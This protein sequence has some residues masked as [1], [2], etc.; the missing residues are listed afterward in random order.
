MAFRL[1]LAAAAVSLVT[2]CAT[3]GAPA[4]DPDVARGREQLVQAFDAAWVRVVASG[5]YYRILD[6][7]PK[8]RPGAARS[9]M[10][11]LADCLPHPDLVTFPEKPVGM[12]KRIIDTGEIRRGTQFNPL[13]KGDTAAYFSPISDALLDAMFVEIEKHYGVKL[14]VSEATLQLPSNETT[15][16]VV[17]GR[18]DFIDQLNAT[19]GDTQGMR[20]RA[21]RRFTCSIS[22]VTQ[23]IH[24][25]EKSPLAAKL[26]SWEDVRANK[27]VRI[28]TGPLSTQT[29]KSF[30]GDS[31]VQTK[32]IGDISNCVRAI[33]EG[34]ADVIANP[35]NDLSI[36][37][38]PGYK[39][40]HT[41]IVTG[42]PLWVA[43]EGIVCPS[44]GNP[45][46]ED[47]CR[48][49]EP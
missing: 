33:E 41:L 32:Y 20:R 13:G 29:M 7:F 27:D 4:V 24:V 14:K 2:G 19:G 8:E 31:R 49:E 34:K 39:R 37:G 47:Q 10:V 38:V 6:R 21:S 9:Y 30:L 28:C 44:D 45:K 46:T 26:N 11:E 25:P 48:A 15:S 42:T 17:D 40:I 1:L 43:K 18:A 22:A 35:L 12:F 23:F 5:E 16:L 36:A 3:A